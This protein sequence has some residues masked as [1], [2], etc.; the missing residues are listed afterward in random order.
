VAAGCATT[1]P[2]R[3]SSIASGAAGGVYQPI[4]EAIAR[5]A[6]ESPGLNLPLT[7]EST[8]ASVANLQLIGA[9]KV[10]LALAQ[11]DIAY[12][13]AEGTTLPAFRGKELS[14]LRA[15][16]SLYPEYVHVV[17]ASGISSLEDLRGKRVAL[18]PEGSGTE[19]NALQ[20]LEIAGLKTTDLGQ[21]ER[22]DT[23][24]AATR[25]R[26]G[27]LDAAFFTVGAGSGLVRDLL[28]DGRAKLVAM[29]RGQI[30]R[31]LAKMPF[32]WLDE[33]PAGTYPGQT[34]AV[35]TPS[36]RVLLVASENA[37]AEAVYGLTKALVDNLPAL[38]AA[39]PAVRSLSTDTMLRVVTVPLH[40]GAL[41]LYEER[42]IQQ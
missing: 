27:Q 1:P 11:N 35:S 17:G 28:A 38:Q 31:L 19:Q 24:E 25:L 7:V 13:A 42:K 36:L 30:G 4:A 6:R 32:Y 20:L 37:E 18:G 33:I 23:A 12:Y 41:R 40:K 21:A 5:I 9:G 15:I 39:H 26:A 16:M 8:G 2:V 29:P 22:I 14:S 10:Q 34:A 3:P